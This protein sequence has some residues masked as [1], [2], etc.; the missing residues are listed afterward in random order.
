MP[1]LIWWSPA[2]LDVQ[3]IH[4]FLAGKNLDAAKR[5]VKAIRGGAKILMA[6]PDIGRPVDDIDP[7]CREWLINFGQGGHVVLYRHDRERA[8]IP[9]VRH[10]REV[11]PR[12]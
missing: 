4:R 12:E 2:L 3:R 7:D 5:A 9:A 10:Q 6:R 11:D 1:R 8:V